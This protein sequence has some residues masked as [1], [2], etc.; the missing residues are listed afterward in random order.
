MGDV[1]L[2]KLSSYAENGQ[3]KPQV[4]EPMDHLNI[5]NLQFSAYSEII[6]V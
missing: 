2:L 4:W 3:R 6:H 1:W 5:P